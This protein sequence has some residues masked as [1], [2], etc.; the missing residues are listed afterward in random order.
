MDSLSFEKKN[1]LKE[2][3]KENKPLT[4]PPCYG[5]D[6][7]NV[8]QEQW[9]RRE[10]A[11]KRESELQDEIKILDQKIFELS[12][13]FPLLFA[14]IKKDVPLAKQN[15][16]NFSSIKSFSKISLNDPELIKKYDKA[17]EIHSQKISKNLKDP[18]LAVK[19]K[20]SDGIGFKIIIDGKSYR[21]RYKTTSSI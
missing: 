18:I 13:H 20:S 21:K 19:T 15:L 6:C 12:S 16:K 14:D 2:K 3:P 8:P 4:N 1:R 17:K 10:R 9:D 11:L 5:R 7:V